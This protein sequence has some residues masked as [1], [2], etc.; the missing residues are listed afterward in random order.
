MKLS[1][2]ASLLASCAFGASVFAGVYQY[3]FDG[4]T[5]NNAS[6]TAAGEA[7]LFVEVTAPASGQIAFRFVNDGPIAMSIA[8]VYFDDQ[9]GFQSQGFLDAAVIAGGAGVLFEAGGSPNNLP[10]G[11][12]LSPAFVATQRFSAQNPRPS[13]GV[14]PGES[15]TITFT[16]APGR[17]FADAIT[18]LDAQTDGLRI[19]IHV[20]SFASGNSE[21]FVNVPSPGSLALA[22]LA[23]GVC[24]R[25][26]RSTQR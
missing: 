5:N 7:Q 6:D 12:T 9:S 1:V 18:A 10:G 22:S 4:I 8:Q 19:G 13:N 20:Q 17:T 3:A 15:L 25:R 21:G 24:F 26:R 14:N 23:G 16:L 11:Q 2:A